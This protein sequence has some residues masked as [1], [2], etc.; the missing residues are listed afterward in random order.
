MKGSKKYYLIVLILTTTLLW[1]SC[2]KEITIDIPQPETKIVIEGAIEEGQYPWVFISKNSPYF[3]PVD[4]AVIANLLVWDAKVTVTNGIITDSLHI[5]LDP[6]S[7]PY[8]KYIGS[9]IIGEVGKTYQLKVEANGKTYTASTSIL[10]AVHLDSL[11]FKPDINQDTLGYI[12]IYLVDP[13]TLGNYYR[14]FTKIIGRDHVFL[15]PY[16]SVIDDKF[17]NGQFSEY[18]L[19]NGRNPLEDNLYDDNG[20]DSAGVPRWYFRRGQT[21]VVKLCAIDAFHY[22]FWYSIEQQF[23]TDGNPFASP[24]SARTNINGGALGVWGGYGIFLDTIH[25]P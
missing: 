17:F 21:V 20:K 15:H 19:D 24:I 2:E 13:D 9:T 5:S 14:V 10:P 8:I 11:K 6:Y 3:E 18:S 22:D 12:W 16:P 4:S 23:I 25:L 1:F 7:F